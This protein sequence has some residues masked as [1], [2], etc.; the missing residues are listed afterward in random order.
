[1]STLE[2][3]RRLRLRRAELGKVTRSADASSGTKAE[4]PTAACSRFPWV[5]TDA[6]QREA[7][8]SGQCMGSVA[9]QGVGRRPWM[10]GRHT[11]RSQGVFGVR[12]G[13]RCSDDADA[14]LPQAPHATAG[15]PRKDEH[16]EGRRGN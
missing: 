3:V 7:E 5:D 15:F 2:V 8:R 16:E 14:V 11:C 12:Q 10:P 6:G 1:M 4:A 13:R 9:W